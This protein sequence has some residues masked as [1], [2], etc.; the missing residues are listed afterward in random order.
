MN[1]QIYAVAGISVVTVLVYQLVNMSYGQ[2]DPN[3]F[4]SVIETF[5]ENDG[6]LSN[7]STSMDHCDAVL[8]I[9]Y[10]NKTEYNEYLATCL[11]YSEALNTMMKAFQNSTKTEMSRIL[12][13]L[14]GFS[15]EPNNQGITDGN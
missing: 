7:I 14:G 5:R 4:A 8:D 15:Y 11:K 1:N 3:N 6:M 2:L 12:G 13:G 9:E 10:G